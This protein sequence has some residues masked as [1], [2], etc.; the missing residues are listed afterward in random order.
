MEHHV[1]IELTTT[2]MILRRASFPPLHV[3]M[4]LAVFYKILHH[5]SEDK[6]V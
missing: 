5:L 6:I 2:V 1:R 4:E 3:E